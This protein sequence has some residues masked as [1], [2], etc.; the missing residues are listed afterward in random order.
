MPSIS[1]LEDLPMIGVL[2]QVALEVQ[3]GI[4]MYMQVVYLGDAHGINKPESWEGFRPG[5]AEEFDTLAT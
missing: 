4:K 2:T 3:S 1:Q 5:P